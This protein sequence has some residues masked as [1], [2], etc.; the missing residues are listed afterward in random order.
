[1]SRFES[2]KGVVS[3]HTEAD[4]DYLPHWYAFLKK[5]DWWLVLITAATGIVIALQAIEMKRTTKAMRDGIALQEANFQQWID[6]KNWTAIPSSK[7]E[8]EIGFDLVNSTGWPLT[9]LSTYIK[10]GAAESLRRHD[11]LMAPAQAYTVNRL[12][13]PTTPEHYM[14]YVSSAPAKLPILILVTY[15][16]CLRKITTQELTGIINFSATGTDFQLLDLP[17]LRVGEWYVKQKNQ[18]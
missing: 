14:Q 15:R 2:D 18:N 1:M 10:V 8:F 4:K 11:V 5:S 3:E 12:Y 13:V 9:P 17:N 16:T 7:T 6:V